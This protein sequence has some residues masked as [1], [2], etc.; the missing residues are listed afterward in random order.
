MYDLWGH[1]SMVS[2]R[3][4]VESYAK[5]IRDVVRPDDVVLDLGCGIGT[6]TVMAARRARRVYAVD[7]DDSV[8][9][10]KR[11]VAENG[12]ADRVTLFRGKVEDLA[13]PEPPTVLVTDVRGQLPFDAGAVDAWNGALRLLAPG[14]R[15][16]PL[17]DRLL[18]QPVRSDRLHVS[19]AGFGPHGGVTFECLRAPLANGRFGDPGDLAPWA[20]PRRVFEIRYGA[21]LDGR[22]SGDL[23]FVADAPWV[24]DG[25]AIGFE[26][27]LSPGV[28]FRSIGPDRAT[29]YGVGVFASP[30]RLEVAPGERI[31]IR[32]DVRR[33]GA[34]VQLRW[35]FVTR[36]GPQPWQG[37]ILE[38]GQ[39]LDVLKASLPDHVPGPDRADDV[40]AQIL[41]A[42]SRGTSVREAAEAALRVLPAGT[43]PELVRGR[44]REL[45]Q[46]RQARVVRRFDRT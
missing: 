39:S 31:G 17:R 4:R 1:R 5:A 26:A 15:I 38:D 30:R 12:V 10:A 35:A 37:P 8:L 18:A 44:T 24:V 43:S 41:L 7:L 11:V 23:E 3:V 14:A 40:D 27:E 32:I 42:F 19:A 2:D 33:V 16:V 22:W 21:P 13:L 46:R 20:E 28:G 25:F 34:G 6:F 29:A 45:A 9:Y 36:D